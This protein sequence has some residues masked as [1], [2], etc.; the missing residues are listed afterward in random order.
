[1]LYLHLRWSCVNNMLPS[2]HSW[3]PSSNHLFAPILSSPVCLLSFSL[4][5]LC[6]PSNQRERMEICLRSFLP[7][8][9]V[10]GTHGGA[11]RGAHEEYID[12]Q[13]RSTILGGSQQQG[14][15]HI[16]NHR[17]CSG[18]IGRCAAEFCGWNQSL[19]SV[20]HLALNPQI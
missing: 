14:G 7:T 3:C 5:G 1:M 17:H 15:S 6:P 10:T 8:K 16:S 18:R 4:P 11:L 20:T 2:A 13:R 19:T 12:A 9:N